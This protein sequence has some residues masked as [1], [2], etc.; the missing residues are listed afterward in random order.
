MHYAWS[1]DDNASTLCSLQ[2]PFIEIIIEITKVSLAFT[3]IILALP[4][5]F[6]VCIVGDFIGGLLDVTYDFIDTALN[7]ISIHDGYLRNKWNMIWTPTKTTGLDD[8]TKFYT[9]SVQYRT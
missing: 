8:A 9:Q 3:N 6:Q 2:L 5:Y 7:L 4:F 1:N